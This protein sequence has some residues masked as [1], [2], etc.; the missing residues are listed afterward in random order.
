MTDNLLCWKCGGCLATLPLPFGRRD[1]CPACG[2]D[3]HVCR[4]CRFYDP[5]VG[6]GCREPLAE[7]VSDKERA[8]FCGYFQ[9]AAD[10][11]RARDAAASR[12]A[13]ARLDELFGAPS[14]GNSAAQ[15]A[16]D[17]ARARLDELFGDKDGKR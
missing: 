14:A 6:Q 15:D 2:A 5:H 17:D 11:Y 9:P 10:A 12:T 13:K 3:L 7:A 4:M 16:A 8:N 1:D